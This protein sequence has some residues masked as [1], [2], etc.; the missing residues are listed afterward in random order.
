M[1][2]R[3]CSLRGER[4]GETTQ[5]HRERWP[6]NWLSVCVVTQESGE[7]TR[8]ILTSR[9]LGIRVRNRETLDEMRDHDRDNDGDGA[10]A[11]TFRVLPIC[12]ALGYAMRSL[13]LSL[14]LFRG[15]ELPKCVSVCS[16]RRCV[17]NR[18]EYLKYRN[19]V[20]V[21]RKA[22]VVQQRWSSLNL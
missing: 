22:L 7:K 6:I 5:N 11:P 9:W 16:A 13:S 1:N 8:K 19:Q 14:S 4:S 12:D 18:A 15:V 2:G 20:E 17:C 3:V 21:D 10:T